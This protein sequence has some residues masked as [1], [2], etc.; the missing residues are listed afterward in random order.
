MGAGPPN[1]TQCRRLRPY[2]VQPDTIAGAGSSVRIPSHCWASR[3][4][5]PIPNRRLLLATGI[6]P[7]FRRKPESRSFNTSWTPGPA[8]DCD[9]GFAGMTTG[10]GWLFLRRRHC[11]P[12]SLFV[13]Q[14]L[15]RTFPRCGNHLSIRQN[16][17]RLPYSEI[18]G[19]KAIWHDESRRGIVGDKLD[20]G[21]VP[22][23]GEF[24]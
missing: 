5:R 24:L 2:T 8:P 15:G 14:G 11:P 21:R 17:W 22:L 7:S 13:K 10:T 16:F 18:P 20:L 3:Q 12:T 4:W 23:D 9:P 19:L 6:Y 1:P